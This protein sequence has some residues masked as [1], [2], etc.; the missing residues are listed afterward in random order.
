VAH[1]TNNPSKPDQMRASSD[2]STLFER[3]CSGSKLHHVSTL[4]RPITEGA[5]C[6]CNCVYHSLEGCQLAVILAGT[7]HQAFA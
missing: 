7:Y 2:S 1:N 4:S 6:E 3:Q 5:L